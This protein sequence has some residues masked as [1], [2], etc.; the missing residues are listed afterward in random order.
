MFI[1]VGG[2]FGNHNLP[3][4]FLKR[5]RANTYILPL[6]TRLLILFPS[7]LNEVIHI[8]QPQ[9]RVNSY[10]PSVFPLNVSISGFIF[11]ARY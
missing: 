3:C 5:N 11:P 4:S 8:S 6:A 1:N 7:T 2:N 10:T 9:C